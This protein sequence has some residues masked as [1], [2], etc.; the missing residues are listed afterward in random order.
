MVYTCIANENNQHTYL[1]SCFESCHFRPQTGV[2]FAQEV[3]L[4]GQLQVLGDAD[5]ILLLVV[6]M[7]VPQRFPHLLDAFLFFGNSVWSVHY[8]SRHERGE[9][10]RRRQEG[11]EKDICLM[12]VTFFVMFMCIEA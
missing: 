6:L 5:E 7:L 9:H 1:N 12:I 2:L 3:E 11:V 10:G 4:S 8:V